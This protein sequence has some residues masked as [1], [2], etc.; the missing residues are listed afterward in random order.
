MSKTDTIFTFETQ[1]GKCIMQTEELGICQSI[2]EL[3]NSE[4]F[5]DVVKKF[6]THLR[7]HDSPLLGIFAGKTVDEKGIQCLLNLLRMLSKTRIDGEELFQIQKGD[8]IK[9]P[10]LL[11]AFVEALYNYWRTFERFLIYHPSGKERLDPRAYHAFNQTMEQFTGLVRTTYRQV[12]ENITGDHPKVYRQVCAGAQIGLVTANKEW[13]CVSKKYSELCAVPMIRQILLVPPLVID[14][15]MNTRSGQFQ[16][17]N[18]NPLMGQELRADK[19]LCYPAKVGPLLIHVFF[20]R[21]FIELGCSLANLFE[22]ASEKEL[23]RTPDAICVYGISPDS[24]ISQYCLSSAEFFDDEENNMLVGVIPGASQFGYFG[25]LKK[26]ILTLHNIKMMKQKRMPFHGALVQIL[27]KDGSNSTVLI[28]GDTGTGKSETL[29]AF[30]ALSSKHLRCMIIIADDMGS[31]EIGENQILRG[32]GTEIGAFVRLDDLQPGYALG[33]ID[34]AIIMSSQKV[35]ARAVLPITTLA[36]VLKG[37]KIDFILYANNYEEVDED[38]LIVERFDFKE[39]AIRV[40]RDG[41][42]MAKGT[43]TSV[44]VGHC[45]FANPFGPVQYKNLHD[46]LAELHFQTAFDSGVFVGQIRTR[47]GIPG[48]ETKGPK[49]AAK[50]LLDLISSQ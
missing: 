29:E 40:F 25:Y 7:R 44:G 47:L 4:L 3:T 23:Q 15:P 35:N 13:P 48:W 49:E 9:D 10:E 28:I 19:W 2:E 42:S 27:L 26:M 31:L 32:Y 24:C 37:Y 6:I 50:T 34:R 12:Q 43:T 33:Q 5:A 46:V 41:T 21:K 1:H 8:W 22:L 36:E 18:I 14:P 39:D 30:R 45:Y 20:S 17:V 16:Q 11:S 38:H